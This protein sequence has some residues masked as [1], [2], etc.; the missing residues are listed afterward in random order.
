MNKQLDLSDVRI[1]T[2]KDVGEAIDFIGQKVYMSDDDNFE[3]Y[4]KLS[5]VSVMYSKDFS[6]AFMGENDQGDCS[7]YKYFILEKDVKFK[8]SQLRPFRTIEEFYKEVS[9]E[10]GDVIT[11]KSVDGRFEETCV[12]NGFRTFENN[13]T[14]VYLGLRSYTFQELSKNYLYLRNEEWKQFGVKNERN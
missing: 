2:R 6:Y 13:E 1:Y 9:C 11:F 4:S 8:D 3:N 10:V 14:T 7:T 5:L 12:F